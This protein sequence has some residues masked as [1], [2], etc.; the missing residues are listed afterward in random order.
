MEPEARTNG[1]QGDDDPEA[2]GDPREA[3]APPGCRVVD[4]C[5]HV[6]PGIRRSFSPHLSR[7]PLRIGFVLQGGSSLHADARPAVKV[8]LVRQQA[9]QQLL[10]ELGRDH[11]GGAGRVAS[12][13]QLHEVGPHDGPAQALQDADHVAGREAAGLGV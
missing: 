4:A 7:A 5:P 8:V 10:G 2:D 12:G 11:R 13:V 6:D 3:P 1:D 9:G